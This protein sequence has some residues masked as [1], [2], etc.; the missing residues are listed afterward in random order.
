MGDDLHL[1]LDFVELGVGQVLKELC[2]LEVGH[3][4]ILFAP[5]GL[6]QGSTFAA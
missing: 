5:G 6:L 3:A 1:L 2:L 4:R